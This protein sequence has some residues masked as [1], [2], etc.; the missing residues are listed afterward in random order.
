MKLLITGGAG[1]IGTHLSRR[2]L[3]HGA[4]VTI[5]DNFSPQIHG[6]GAG[7]S[8]DLGPHVRLI[9]ADIQDRD[10]LE[11][12]LS[13]QDVVVH[14][15]A[16]TG[17]GQS[18]Y[19]VARYQRTNLG[20]TATLFDILIN[21]SQRTV[22][23]IVTASSR[24]IYG[25]GKYLCQSHGVV[26]PLARLANAMA[27]GQFEPVCPTCGEPC[28]ALPTDEATPARP[29]SFYGLTK[30]TQESMT[31][32][33]GEA[34]GVSAYALRYQNV[35]G[36]GQS[37][38]NPY[39]GV[40]AVF[41]NLAR[42]NRPILIFEDG[43]ESRDFVYIAD[44]V[45]ATWCSVKK[46]LEAGEPSQKAI[47]IGS[48]TATS[49]SEM[50]QQVVSYFQSASNLHITGDFRLGDIRHN[51]ADLTRAAETLGFCPQTIFSEGLAAFLAWANESRP[52]N[53]GY[54]RSLAELRSKGL[55]SR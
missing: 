51:V 41:S 16:D 48:G 8:A 47:N 50:A 24:A 26:F 12:A 46:C 53:S 20:G 44:V 18:M 55:M 11:S 39:T 2:A 54:D 9:R 52:D 1:F 23:G 42:A 43:R 37:L 38:K 19:E 22:Q 33:F 32:M 3:A 31:L 10:A 6:V 34:L 29:A 14:L 28:V 45:E 40:L 5:L 25:E 7:L 35:Y 13:G 15:A 4:T 30:L 27:N 49:I 36:P 17:T 21:D